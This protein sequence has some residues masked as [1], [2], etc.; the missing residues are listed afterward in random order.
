[1]CVLV[2]ASFGWERRKGEGL[3]VGIGR[4]DKGLLALQRGRVD[5]VGQLEVLDR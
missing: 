3:T 2:Q 1:M 4:V 5:H